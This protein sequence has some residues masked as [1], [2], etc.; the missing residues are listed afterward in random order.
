M[1][2]LT[3][4]H[5]V[6][7]RMWRSVGSGPLSCF[8]GI[9]GF[10]L[11][12]SSL[13]A[14]QIA[15]VKTNDRTISN[16]QVNVSFTI[17][18]SPSQASFSPGKFNASFTDTLAASDVAGDGQTGPGKW[19]VIEKRRTGPAVLVIKLP[20]PRPIQNLQIALRFTIGGGQCA[21]NYL[22][23]DFTNNASLALNAYGGTWN[24]SA[25]TG[26]FLTSMDYTARVDP[27][28]VLVDG[29]Q[30]WGTSLCWWANIAGG[31]TNRNDYA[32]L[33]FNYLKLN[34]VRYNI[35][36][37]ENP[38][39]PGTLEFRASMPSF[40][41]RPGVWDWNA[42]ANQRWML[43]A[44]LARGADHVE[45]F[46]NSPPYWMTVSGSV[47]GSKGG[48]NNLQVAREEDF[49][50]YLAEVVKHLSQSDGVTF[51][52]VTPMNEP[53]GSWWT[54]G[55]ASEG[56]HMSVDQQEVMINLLRAELDRRELNLPIDASEDNDEQS[57]VNALSTYS[58]SVRN[59]VG[60]IATHTYGANNASGLS[61][62]AQ[63]FHKPLWHTEYGDD[64]GTGMR[65]A[66]RIRDDLA[67][68]HPLSWCYW[69]VVDNAGGWG[70][71]YNP[72]DGNGSTAYTIHR[73]FYVIGQFSRFLRPGCK[74]LGCGDANSIAGYDSGANTLAIVTVN[75]QAA[76]FTVTFDLG[77]FAS[78]G[79]GVE[80]YR[81][82]ASEKLKLLPALSVTDRHFTALI[83]AHSVTTFVLQQVILKA[84]KQ[85]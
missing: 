66:R 29:F 14:Q 69:Q 77:G 74:I 63:S 5:M 60:Q 20:E 31:Y 61:S 35:G 15:I 82:S 81:T 44:A 13:A 79:P 40:E 4:M 62:I 28:K 36:G 37:G 84:V 78:T 67:W 7:G 16:L 75:D 80:C 12:L 53:A 71:I 8:L 26:N 18:N 25:W 3:K 6:A 54:Y 50:V 22:F 2:F 83:P 33:A 23:A 11:S 34:I 45:A 57:A 70:M 55:R 48:A 32:D 73:K 47:T 58:A 65:T 43:K 27:E 49:A 39:G 21:A 19:R 64:D 56:C 85:P 51:H 46:A 17:S 41:P 9:L 24:G 72:L 10:A 68:L 59:N 38:D 42:D 30:G 1:M 52:S 76:D